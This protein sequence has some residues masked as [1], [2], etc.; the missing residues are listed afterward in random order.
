[1][2]NM[3]ALVSA[4]HLQGVALLKFRLQKPDA[5]FGSFVAIVNRP[6]TAGRWRLALV[7]CGRHDEGS[8]VA[9]F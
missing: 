1:M 5:E 9:A 6:E 7:G 8:S 3:I 4:V 2:S